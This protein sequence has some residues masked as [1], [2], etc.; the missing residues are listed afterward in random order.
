MIAKA[1]NKKKFGVAGSRGTANARKSGGG[2][3][4]IIEEARQ[5]D[6]FTGNNRVVEAVTPG[7]EEASV[8]PADDEEAL[9]LGFGREYPTVPHEP[10]ATQ[11]ASNSIW[12]PL[13]E[14]TPVP[15]DEALRALE[16]S[17]RLVSR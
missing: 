4:G 13:V 12:R 9:F 2:I 10:D 16:A 14:P 17:R 1:T 11:I 5:P 6:E 8:F 3:N 15:T 7:S